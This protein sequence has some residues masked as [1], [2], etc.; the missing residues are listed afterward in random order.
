MKKVL[1]LWSNIDVHK[2]F[3][4]IG[5]VSKSFVLGL[6]KQVTL[7]IIIIIIIIIIKRIDF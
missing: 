3:V 1:L 6:T 7:I 4:V 2:Y 5:L